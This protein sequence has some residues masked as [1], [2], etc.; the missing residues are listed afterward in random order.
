MSD[1]GNVIRF[2]DLRREREDIVELEK[3]GGGDDSGGMDG[4]I[5]RI[6]T[7]LDALSEAMTA[8]RER[9]AKIEGKID[10]LPSTWVMVTTIVGSQVAL[11]GFTFAILRF[12]R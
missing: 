2:S 8:L 6:E 4:R 9:L 11:L 10:N 1:Q 12:M 5:T 7:R 3:G